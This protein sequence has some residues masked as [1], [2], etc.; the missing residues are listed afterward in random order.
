MAD[1][2]SQGYARRAIFNLKLPM[3]K[4]REE[5]LACRALVEAKLAGTDYQWRAKQLYHDREEVTVS[6]AR[7]RD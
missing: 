2:L 7:R 1:W 5:V 3:K 4:R 6:L